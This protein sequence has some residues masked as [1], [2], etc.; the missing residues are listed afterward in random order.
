MAADHGA[1]ARTIDVNIACNQFRFDALDVRGTAGEKSAGQCVVRI[2]R[3]PDGFIE[4]ADSNDAQDR[5]ENFFAREAHRWAHVSE[6]RRRDEVA[7]G[8]EVLSLERE[9]R[10]LFSRF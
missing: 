6:N 9:S 8:W 3:N 2:V 1:R 10:F 4:I 7:F 5:S